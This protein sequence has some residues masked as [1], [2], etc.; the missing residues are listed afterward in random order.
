MGIVKVP[1]DQDP[2]TL[3]YAQK[4]LR[5]CVSKGFGTSEVPKVLSN[6][7]IVEQRRISTVDILRRDLRLKGG[8]VTQR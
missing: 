5:A 3:R 1:Y 7:Q 6:S 2:R 8:F 4:E